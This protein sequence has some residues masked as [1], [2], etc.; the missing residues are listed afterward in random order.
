MELLVKYYR[1]YLLFTYFQIII[2]NH[3][4]CYNKHTVTLRHFL[5]CAPHFRAAGCVLLQQIFL[6]ICHVQYEYADQIMNVMQM[7]LVGSLKE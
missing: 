6:P 7:N 1:Y 3:Y 2:F 4:E 5:V